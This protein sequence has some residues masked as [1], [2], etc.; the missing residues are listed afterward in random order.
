MTPLGA[1]YLMSD[2]SD[3]YV[4]IHNSRK[5]LLWSNNEKNLWLW[6]TTSWRTVLKGCSIRKAENLCFR[7]WWK[8][9]TLSLLVFKVELPPTALLLPWLHI[10]IRTM[11]PPFRAS[12][13]DKNYAIIL[14]LKGMAFT[15][16]ESLYLLLTRLL[17]KYA[18]LSFSITE[19]CPKITEL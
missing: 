10:Y 6:V 4:M 17:S 14:S 16:L 19:L 1:K 3:I 15:E 7:F 11:P 18:R 9:A 8:L 12:Y 13:L 2:I 5:L